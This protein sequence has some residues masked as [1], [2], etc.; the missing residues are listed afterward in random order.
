MNLGALIAT[1]GVDATGLRMAEAEMRRF[2]A[3]ANTA[4]A[5]VNAKLATT[6]KTMKKFGRTWSM[7]VTAPI[8]LAGGAA[9]KMHMDFESSMSKIIGL[10][11]V[12]RKQVEAW[13]ADILK[14]APTLGKS[15]KELADAMFFIT[16]AGI[17]GAEALDVLKMS[18]K[19]SV[20]GLGETKV[21]ADLV[22]SAMNA[23][24]KETLN[25]Q[26]ATDVLTAAVREGKAQADALAGSMGMV[27]PIASNMGVT[28]D[29]VGAAVAAMTRTGT[30]AQ[31]ASIQLRQI[32]NSLVKPSQQAEKAM[33]AMGTSSAALRKT[34]REEGLLAALMKIRDL[35]NKYGEDTMAKVFPNI[36]ALSGVL[37]IMGENLEDNIAIF[38]SLEEATGSSNAA[39]KE[40]SK[41]FEYKWNVAVKSAGT[42]LTVFGKTVAEQLIP[43]LQGFTERIQK[44]VQWFDSLNQR[45]K[46][47]IVRIA[48]LTAAIGPLSIMLGWLVGNVIPGL[49]KLGWGAIKMF[50]ALTIAML[51]NPATAVAIGIG[52]LAA[53]LLIFRKRAREA[54]NAQEK[55]NEQLEVTEQIANKR[56]I[57]QF[58]RDVGL[59]QKQILEGP[60]GTF[61]EIEQLNVTE[62]ALSR[63]NEMMAKLPVSYLKGVKDLISGQIIELKRGL[64]NF[65]LTGNELLDQIE[66]SHMENETKALQSALIAVNKE[67]ERA[68][69]ITPLDDGGAAKGLREI[70][71]IMRELSKEIDFAVGMEKALGEQFDMTTVMIQAHQKALEG[72]IR[73]GVDPMDQ[74]IKNLVTTINTLS[75]ALEG[76]QDALNEEY[77]DFLEWSLQNITRESERLTQEINNMIL[78]WH[79]L[80]E[81]LKELSQVE[82]T[83]AHAATDMAF[84]L[85]KAFTKSEG[86]F[87]GMVDAILSTS[88]QIIGTLLLEAIAGMIAGESKKGLIGFV[89][90]AIGIG[91]IM[92]L[93]ESY[94]NK[95]MEAAAVPMAVGGEVP[96][97]FPG[98][99]YPAMLSSGERVYPEPKPLG[100][101]K[102]IVPYAYQVRNKWP[103][104]KVIFEIEGDNLVATYDAMKSK[105]EN[106]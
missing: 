100:I 64:E 87:M 94:K 106:Y 56:R 62:K 63:L 97:G 93:W 77:M 60:G 71:A 67:L 73:A 52:A 39:F 55:F 88:Q 82:M 85:G 78:A 32:L 4:L 44:V 12:S 19:A 81:E 29:Q 53:H 79:G 15:P 48:A 99:T 50:K 41:T 101:E 2:E 18:A 40:A 16:S 8:A 80:K 57:E 36:R 43:L 5:S 11:G 9:A 38:K 96:P 13:S 102:A 95:A 26:A 86:A 72:L 74:R 76:I 1:L 20:S 10:V 49:I 23:Y 89:T 22:T 24:G 14:L 45:Q 34:I 51:K 66:I 61:I 47:T 21:I 35:T 42:V 6:G 37:D 75:L 84:Q 105:Q 91:A 33:W 104:E 7:A 31:T 98:D 25:A 27:L 28:F 83:L 30:N 65:V 90:A 69:K 92:G 58:L 54:T 3:R 70:D 103:P 68:S 46:S 59:L 17:R